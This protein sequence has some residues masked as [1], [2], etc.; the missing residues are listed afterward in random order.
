[1]SAREL[2]GEVIFALT[3][4]E[5]SEDSAGFLESLGFAHAFV[6]EG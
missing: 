5:G 4:M 3:E 6:G 2:V 1:L